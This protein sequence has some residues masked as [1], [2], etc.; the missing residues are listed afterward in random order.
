MTILKWETQVTY[1]ADFNTLWFRGPRDNARHGQSCVA[2]VNKVCRL[3]HLCQTVKV[4][5]HW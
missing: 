3:Q 5:Q 4:R 2:G 1:L